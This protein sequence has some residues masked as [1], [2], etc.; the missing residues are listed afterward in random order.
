[1]SNPGRLRLITSPPL[2]FV[3]GGKDG[4]SDT[5]DGGTGTDVFH[6]LNA[7]TRAGFNAGADSI[8]TWNGDVSAG[9][10]GTSANEVF[11]LSHLTS[12]T[13]L[14]FVDGG[15]GNDTITGTDAWAGVL[16]GNAGNDTLT[17]G[18]NDDTLTGGAG[19]DILHG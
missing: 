12:V 18:T 13:N 2:T 7:V 15:G 10:T 6:A 14:A 5:F 9:I 17:G 4:Q 16:R 3:V 11:D 8:E 19:N 1:M